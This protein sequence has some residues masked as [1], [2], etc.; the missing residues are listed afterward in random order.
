[1]PPDE[2]ESADAPAAHDHGLPTPTDA[3]ATEPSAATPLPEGAAPVTPRRAGLLLVAAIGVLYLATSANFLA[4][5]SPHFHFI[6]MAASWLDGRLDTDTPRRRGGVPGKPEDRPGYQAAI[7]RATDHGRAGWNDWASY[8]VLRLA[9]GEEVRGVFP[10]KD[11][12]G[13]RQHEFWTVDGTAMVIDPTRDLAKG[14]DADRPTAPCDRVVYQV[15]FPPFPALLML[16]F[17]AVIGYHTPDV[18]LTLLFALLGPLLLLRWL[19]RWRQQGLLQL[20]VRERLWLVALFSL[21]TVLWYCSI[22]GTVWFSALAI[23]VPLHLCYLMAAEGARRPALAGLLL[24]VGVATRTPLLF[25]AVFLPL[26]ALFPNGRW[27]GGDG[28]RGLR[29][30]LVQIAW[31]ALPMAI[32]GAGLA[33]FNA[34]RWQ[35]PMEFGHFYLLEGTRAPTRDYGL[36]SFHFLNHNLGAALTNLPKLVSVPPYLL[37]SRHGLGTLAATPALLLLLGCRGASTPG[38]G[39]TD[40]G[41]PLARRRR[42]LSRH[43]GLT[44]AAIAVPGLLYQNDGWQ[45]FAYRFAVDL[46]PPLLGVFALH[47]GRVDRRVK[48]LILISIAIELFG[49]ITFGRFE[50]F[51]YD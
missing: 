17:V 16:P 8:R 44:V 29:R 36:F 39:A 15:S 37:I 26:E 34:V 50:Q 9:G 14:C 41:D 49:A 24:G 28:G 10:Y 40:D 21:G 42:A 27:L 23:G 12:P 45:Q 6:D 48:A 35:N 33:W 4:Q 20:D 43:L 18:L 31:F 32:I 13:P 3:P 51:Y 1:M 22:R 38:T 46:W 2:P 11:V 5:P 30:A 47:V 19:D 7:D 25:A